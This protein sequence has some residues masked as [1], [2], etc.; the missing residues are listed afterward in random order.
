M[1]DVPAVIFQVAATVWIIGA[2]L[3]DAPVRVHASP[4]NNPCPTY[5]VL[6]PQREVFD[7]KSQAYQLMYAPLREGFGVVVY[8]NGVLMNEG[9]DYTLDDRTVTFTG[10]RPEDMQTVVVQVFYQ[11]LAQ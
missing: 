3:G 6:S 1:R 9:A 5:T 7:T 2:M 8:L 4:Q 11:R 10:Q